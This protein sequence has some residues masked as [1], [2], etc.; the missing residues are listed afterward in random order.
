MWETPERGPA[1][2]PETDSHAGHRAVV[3]VVL[4]VLVLARVDVLGGRQLERGRGGE[5]PG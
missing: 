3:L 2:G 5:G 1:R 4:V